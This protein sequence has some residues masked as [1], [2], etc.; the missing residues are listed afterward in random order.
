MSFAEQMPDL[1]NSKNEQSEYSYF[2]AAKLKL[3]AGPNIWKYTNLLHDQPT[4]T[5]T[6]QQKQAMMT[7][8]KLINLNREPTINKRSIRV[9]IFQTSSVEKLMSKTNLK[10]K[11]SAGTSQSAVLLR[12]RE[13]NLNQMQLARKIRKLTDL[14]N[15][16][17]FPDLNSDLLE[18]INRRFDRSEPEIRHI[19]EDEFH[20]IEN[21]YHDESKSEKH[22]ISTSLIYMKINRSSLIDVV[23][24]VNKI[25]CLER[26][27]SK[28]DQ[29]SFRIH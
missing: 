14:T 19:D 17:H 22:I 12:G 28:N 29:E 3:F 10:E 27:P 13:K 2:D 23:I 26:I 16:H 24:N 8:K 5:S 21:D 9:D 25:N 6:V 1:L 4:E 15:F 7:P 11:R 18:R 20:S